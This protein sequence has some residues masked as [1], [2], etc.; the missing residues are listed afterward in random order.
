M[1][2]ETKQDLKCTGMIEKCAE[3]VTHIDN[4][5]FIFCGQCGPIR[6]SSR[7]TRKMTKTE[8]K[9]LENHGTISYSRQRK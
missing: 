6:K 8:I 9:T 4:K 7:P 2:N 3:P 5:G 1:I